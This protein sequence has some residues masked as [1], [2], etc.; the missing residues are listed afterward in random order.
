MTL[1]SLSPYSNKALISGA[2]RW[3]IKYTYLQDI[4]CIV[5]LWIQRNKSISQIKICM[6]GEWMV[7]GDDGDNNGGSLILLLLFEAIHTFLAFWNFMR[8]MRCSSFFYFLSD[9]YLVPLI[10]L[11][12]TCPFLPLV[13]LFLFFRDS[14]H[15]LLFISSYFSSFFRALDNIASGSNKIT[16]AF[17][18]Q[19]KTEIFL[20]ILSRI[21]S[22]IFLGG[23]GDGNGWIYVDGTSGIEV[24]YMSERASEILI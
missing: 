2:H 21:R 3:E 23:S 12:D 1:S 13:S 8:R 24:A 6:C 10:L 15:L 19:G 17:I 16:W 9:G 4:Y 20:A 14:E 11:S 5:K 18:S 7:Y 22:R